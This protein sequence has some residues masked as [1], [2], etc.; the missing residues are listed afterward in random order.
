MA[1]KKKVVWLVIDVPRC[2]EESQVRI[3]SGAPALMKL[4]TTFPREP[5][6]ILTF[7]LQRPPS[8]SGARQSYYD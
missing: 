3:V 6:D 2:S 5:Y 4:I 1:Y 7:G 8:A